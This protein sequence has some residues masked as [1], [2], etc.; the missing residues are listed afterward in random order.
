MAR[1]LT[2]LTTEELL[3]MAARP[4]N[5]KQF[6]EA[7]SILVLRYKNLIYRATLWRCRGN[8]A[9][10]EDAFQ[11]TFLRLFTWLRKRR[12]KPPLHSFARLLHV[13]AQGAIVDLMRK[14][15]GQSGP[16]VDLVP[17][18]ESSEVNLEDSLYV[19]ELLEFFEPRCREVLR[20]TYFEG[21]SAIQIADSLGLT[22]ENVRQLR[23]RALETLR[24]M[25][26]RDQELDSVEEV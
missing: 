22:P 8:T 2:D 7:V 10:A 1:D 17:E 18:P 9:L 3:A 25:K 11:E 24:E 16:D 20:S 4:S 12:G 26:V 5:E 14:E 23:F 13:F 19:S 6:A 21:L 15:L